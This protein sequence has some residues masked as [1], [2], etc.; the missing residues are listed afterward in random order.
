MK[1]P[2][3]WVGIVVGVGGTRG[4]TLDIVSFWDWIPDIVLDELDDAGNRIGENRD[5]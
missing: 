2:V 3:I 4:D 1:Y 5:C